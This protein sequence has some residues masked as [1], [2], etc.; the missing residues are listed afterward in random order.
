MENRINFNTHILTIN[1]NF[2][3]IKSL[4]VELS[5]I[6]NE[7]EEK[8][9]ALSKL[10]LKMIKLNQPID[11]TFGLDSFH[12]QNKL[13]EYEHEGLIEIFNSIS[14]RMYCEYYKLYKMI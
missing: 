5:Q 13:I 1:N 8:T 10:Y 6:F 7:I 12:F 14:N 11:Y 9:N 2:L 4:R 3:E